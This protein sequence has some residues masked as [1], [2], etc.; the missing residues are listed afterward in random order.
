MKLAGKFNVPVLRAMETVLS[1]SGWRK[2]SSTR[3][4]NSGSS[5][6]NK[7]QNP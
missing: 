7:R 1:S 6:R 2:T 3:E 4:P 5:S